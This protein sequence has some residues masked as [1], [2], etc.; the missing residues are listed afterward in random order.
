MI[1]DA[2]EVARHERPPRQLAQGPERQR[3]VHHVPNERAVAVRLEAVRVVPQPVGA[4]QL[5]VDEAPPWLPHLDARQP[6]NR[7]PVQPQPVLDQ[8][9]RPHLDPPRRGDP[10]AQPARRDRLEVVRVCEESEHLAGTAGHPLRALDQMDPHPSGHQLRSWSGACQ[11]TSIATFATTPA[12]AVACVLASACFTRPRATIAPASPTWKASRASSTTR[13]ALRPRTWEWTPRAIPCA[14]CA[15]RTR[16][17]RSASTTACPCRSSRWA[18]PRRR[19][20]TGCASTTLASTGSPSRWRA[21]TATTASRSG[22]RPGAGSA[23]TSISAEPGAG[24]STAGRATPS[25]S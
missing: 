7:Q 14:W 24:T 5:D 1:E 25:G 19:S 6:A 17:G 3:V 23:S 2:L 18:S 12:A 8:G 21:G 9:A 4:A 13:R 11:G 22:T 15:T 16:P 20:A 10:K